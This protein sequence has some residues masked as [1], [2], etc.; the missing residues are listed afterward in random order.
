[1]VTLESDIGLLIIYESLRDK[2]LSQTLYNSEFKI[3]QD[4]PFIYFI[5]IVKN[6]AQPLSAIITELENMYYKTGDETMD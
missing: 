2:L 5:I 3:R 1:M 6:L 4:I